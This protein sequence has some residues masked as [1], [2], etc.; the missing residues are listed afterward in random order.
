[1]SD[2]GPAE[3]LD[4]V[5]D[6]SP[7]VDDPV[8]ARHRVR[9]PVLEVPPLS[10][11]V[12]LMARRN[13]EDRTRA[14]YI[15]VMV[16]RRFH[17]LLVDL[18]APNDVQELALAILLH[19]QRHVTL[20]LGAARALGSPGEIAF[21][22]AEL[23]QPRSADGPA[24]DALEMV[25]ATFALGEVTALGLIR[26]A[27]RDVPRS[28]F[29]E[30][31]AAIARD[32]VLHARIGPALLAAARRGETSAWLPWPGDVAVRALV[33]RHRAALARRAVVEPEDAL[34]ARDSA[35]AAELASV[36]ISAGEAFRAAYHRALTHDVARTWRRFG[37]DDLL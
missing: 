31:L 25:A 13:W 20:C 27:L 26:S 24:A 21:E 19:E 4:L 36:G 11:T 8:F 1:V 32:E 28:G 34:A 14:E 10:E 16:A 22:L 35:V 23:Q 29:R 12:R 9:P 37:L 17:G 6:D 30:I 7:L 3:G 33:A 15:G 2:P 5:F 18:N